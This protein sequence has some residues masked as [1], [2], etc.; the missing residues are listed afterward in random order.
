MEERFEELIVEVQEDHVK[1]LTSASPIKALEELI[2]NALDSVV[3][4]LMPKE[5]YI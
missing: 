4:R 3:T 5:K 2:Y 1:A